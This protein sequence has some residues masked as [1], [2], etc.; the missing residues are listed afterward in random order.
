MSIHGGTY[1]SPE[2]SRDILDRGVDRAV[3][4]LP[5]GFT[6]RPLQAGAEL[7]ELNWV[8]KAWKLGNRRFKKDVNAKAYTIGMDKLIGHLGLTQRILVLAL[9]TG[10]PGRDEILGFI[11]YRQMQPDDPA[12]VVH[13]LCIKGEYRRNGAATLLLDAAGWKPGMPIVGTSKSHLP[14]TIKHKWNVYFN[15]FFLYAGCA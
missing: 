13:Y 1:V 9:P 2:P 8:R 15:D 3:R 4:P 12:I 7:S 14:A 6:I 11:C 5:V 10:V